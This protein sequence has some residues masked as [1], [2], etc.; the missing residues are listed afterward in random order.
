MPIKGPKSVSKCLKHR[1]S[2]SES[3]E[4]RFKNYLLYFRMI[5]NDFNLWEWVIKSCILGV[6][7]CST[8]RVPS[9]SANI[10]QESPKTRKEVEKE[11]KKGSLLRGKKV[12]RGWTNASRGHFFTFRWSDVLSDCNF[13][14]FYLFYDL[15]NEHILFKTCFV[16][17]TCCSLCTSAPDVKQSARVPSCISCLRLA[18]QMPAERVSVLYF[19]L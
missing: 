8:S 16:S 5:S 15:R 3:S 13:T 10:P 2:F 17:A 19:R 4:M 6:S 14:N 9:E 1:C 11:S 7:F 18:S 12:P